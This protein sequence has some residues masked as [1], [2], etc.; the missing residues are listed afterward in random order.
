MTKLTPHQIASQ[1]VD[2]IVQWLVADESTD[3]NDNAVRRA[4]T[5]F[6]ISRRRAVRLVS[7]ASRQFAQPATGGRPITRAKPVWD[8]RQPIYVT[9]DGVTHEARF[10]GATRDSILVVADGKTIVVSSDPPVDEPAWVEGI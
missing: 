7:R 8:M 3:S 9:I 1:R 2:Q 4:I 6:G 10:A 5:E